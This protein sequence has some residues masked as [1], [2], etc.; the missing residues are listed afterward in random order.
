MLRGCAHGD[1]HGRNILVGIVRDRVLWPT[2]FDYEDMRPDNLIAWDFVKLE[3]ELKVRACSEIFARQEP[4]FLHQ[5]RDFEIQLNEQTERHHLDHTW[6][7]VQNDAEPAERLRA[8][9]LELRRMA[10]LH[11]GIYRGRPNQ[12]L[13]EYYFVL[14]GYAVSTARFSN[15]ER[16]ELLAAYVSA[17]VAVSR[18]PTR[19]ARPK[20]NPPSS[21]FTQTVCGSKWCGSCIASTGLT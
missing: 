7:L 9:L 17:G 19:T 3:S 13:E 12:W 18:L 2:V 5:V 4:Q 16:R 10:A 20:G 21:P 6:P 11:L 14:A 8:I 15:L 1:L